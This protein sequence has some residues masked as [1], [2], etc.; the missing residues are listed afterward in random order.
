[1]I[2]VI[3]AIKVKTEQ[4]KEFIEIF[5]SNVPEVLKEK[6]CI[7]YNPTVDFEAENP[8]QVK[9]ESVVTIIEKW[10]TVEDLNAHAVSPHMVTYH[11]KVK[12]MVES[13]KLQILENA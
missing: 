6:G 13:V 10:E 5:K 4:K 8:S 2:Y 9:D 12:D 7:E 3:A 1:M 11:E